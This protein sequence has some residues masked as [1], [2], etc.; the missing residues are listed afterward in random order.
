[1]DFPSTKKNYLQTNQNLI[2]VFLYRV[3]FG[4]ARSIIFLL[5]TNDVS[6]TIVFNKKCTKQPIKKSIKNKNKIKMY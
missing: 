2:L 5:V 4:Q 6:K 1:M 3:G